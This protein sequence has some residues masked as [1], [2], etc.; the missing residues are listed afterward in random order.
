MCAAMY[1]GQRATMFYMCPLQILQHALRNPLYKKPGHFAYKP[2]F[3][4]DLSTADFVQTPRFHLV[5]LQCGA[6]ATVL[7]VNFNTDGTGIAKHTEAHFVFAQ[8]ANGRRAAASDL[9]TVFLIAALPSLSSDN[10]AFGGS[11]M[12]KYAH[13]HLFHS[14]WTELLENFNRASHECVTWP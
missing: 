14:C 10:K 6:N 9:S 3:A 2:E 4:E 11:D 7:G 12:K 1:K 5:Q 8:I 13:L